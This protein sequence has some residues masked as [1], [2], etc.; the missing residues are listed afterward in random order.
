MSDTEVAS[1]QVLTL[2]PNRAI[3]NSNAD[4]AE[5]LEALAASIR[6]GNKGDVRHAIVVLH[7]PGQSMLPF[8][9]GERTTKAEL[10]GFLHFAAHA[11]IIGD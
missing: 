10:V 7:S 6:A 9:Y 2:L 1:G 5:R 4:I 8:C 3:A 11:E